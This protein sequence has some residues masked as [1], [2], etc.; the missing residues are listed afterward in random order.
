VDGHGRCF[1]I[2]G[3]STVA[4]RGLIRPDLH[5]ARTR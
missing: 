5:Q 2:T 4:P 3:A 1:V